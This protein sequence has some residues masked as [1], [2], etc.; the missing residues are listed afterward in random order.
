MDPAHTRPLAQWEVQTPL[1]QCWPVA[2]ARPQLPQFAWSLL[3]TTQVLPHR[4]QPLLAG[5]GGL[6]RHAMA[7]PPPH[8]E[9]PAPP[10]PQAH[11]PFAHEP[12]SQPAPEARSAGPCGIA[13]SKG[14]NVTMSP[15]CEIAW[16]VQA[17]LAS[18]AHAVPTATARKPAN[19]LTTVAPLGR[20]PIGESPEAFRSS[21]LTCE[22]SMAAR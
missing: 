12:A 14:G 22:R 21:L 13:R 3:S 1:S 10:L 20:D 9:T 6:W 8:A 17:V 7:L 5:G 15:D 2:H 18:S 4:V 11:A 19:R 16:L